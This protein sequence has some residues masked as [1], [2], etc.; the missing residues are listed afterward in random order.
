M[1]HFRYHL[2]R[3][4]RA[5]HRDLLEDTYRH[6]P[7]RLF[8]VSDNKR[9]CITVASLRDRLVHRLLYE[10]LERIYDPVFI[11]DAWSCRKDKGLHCAIDRAQQFLRT[12]RQGFFWRSDVLKFFDN[13]DHRILLDI[14]RRRVSDNATLT[15]LSEV[16]GSYDSST[17]GAVARERERESNGRAK[18][19]SDRERY[20]PNFREYLLA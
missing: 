8:T 17:L 15:L 13:V 3:H 16:I 20:E 2:E 18:R 9:R 12:H 6:G 14:L 10:Y 11:Y 4:L 7:Y 5:L 1:E 19:N